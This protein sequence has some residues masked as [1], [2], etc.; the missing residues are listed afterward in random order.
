LDDCFQLFCVDRLQFIVA[1]IFSARFIF[2]QG[3][4]WDHFMYLNCRLW[5]L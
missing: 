2:T 1:G 3:I 4:N 5:W